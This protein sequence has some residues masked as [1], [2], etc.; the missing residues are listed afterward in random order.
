MAKNSS[1]EK[2]D[3]LTSNLKALLQEKIWLLD[4]RLQQ[5]RLASSY[6]A[7]TDAEARILAV[8]RGEELTISEIARRLG[9]SRQAVHKIISNLIKRKLLKLEQIE[10]SSR[11]K[12]IIFTQAGEE[13]KKEAAKTLQELEKE[14]EIAIGSRNFQLLKSLLRKEW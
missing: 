2:N 14:V 9:V 1:V 11:D 8:L 7:L 6:K 10:G 4:N 5:K 12:R 3:F 13:M